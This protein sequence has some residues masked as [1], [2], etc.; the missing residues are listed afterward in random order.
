[1]KHAYDPAGKSTSAEEQRLPVVK[2]VLGTVAGA[3]AGI[4]GLGA[5]VYHFTAGTD[6]PQPSAVA[7][8][9]EGDST[10]PADDEPVPALP[11]NADETENVAVPG[12]STA[13]A[14]QGVT[15]GAF[16]S[17]A[18]AKGKTSTGVTMVCTRKAGESQARWRVVTTTTTAPTT[19][20][21]TTTAPT[22]KPATA[23]PTTKPATTAPTTKPTTAPTTTAPTTTAP[24]TAPT[25]A[26]PAA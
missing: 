18:G 17:P 4:L 14:Q 26:A 22:T 19:K 20:P 25:T 8:P 23:A 6:T 9:A 7:A 2:L 10:D 16:C 21:A 24:T 5:V 15:A 3:L 12:A 11:A 1:M 13:P